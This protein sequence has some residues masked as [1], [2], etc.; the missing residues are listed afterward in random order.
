[1]SNDSPLSFEL[2]KA[3]I[4]LDV[5]RV[6]KLLDENP[7]L[8]DARA[9]EIAAARCVHHRPRAHELARLLV[10]RG[11]RPLLQTAARAGLLDRVRELLDAD[12]N[13]L[14]AVDAKGRSAL[15]RAACVYGKFAEGEAVVELLAER[16]AYV[17]LFSACT[18]GDR[19]RVMELLSSDP[20][21]ATSLDPEGMTALH[22]A[23]RVRRHRERAIEITERLLELGADVHAPNPTE[24]G[25]TPLH[26]VAE[27][28]GN[29][30]QAVL[31]LEHGAD[32]NARA[33]HGWTPLDYALDRQRDNMVAL[34]EE[35]GAESGR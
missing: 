28:S 13:R 27:W 29:R 11:A 20:S 31:L 30:G 35:R 19:D 15:Y 23:V 21:L 7:G 5:E 34:L 1:M 3:S 2:R 22:W 6:S 25:M 18:L 17:D 26:H 16:G 4:S 8:A 10:D 12:P 32:L 14:D 9:V 33:D 24:D